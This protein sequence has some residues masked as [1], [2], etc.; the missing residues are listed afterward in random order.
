MSSPTSADVP[1]ADASLSPTR[2]LSG[3]VQI[4]TLRPTPSRPA[5]AQVNSVMAI[6][7]TDDYSGILNRER[8][9]ELMR[10]RMGLS[11]ELLREV[12]QY[13]LALMERVLNSGDDTRTRDA[14]V[15]LLWQHM[16][17][18]DS[19]DILLRA[20]AVTPARVQVRSLVDVALQLLYLLHRNDEKVSAAYTTHYRRKRLKAAETMVGGS[21]KRKEI[22]AEAARTKHVQP[23]WLDRFP[24]STAELQ[25][26]RESLAGPLWAEASAELDRLRDP[27]R[28]FAAFGGPRNLKDLSRLVGMELWSRYVY[29]PWSEPAHGASPQRVFRPFEDG[30]A[31][32]PLRD[33]EDWDQ[34]VD[35]CY[36]LS[37]EVFRAVIDRFRPGEETGFASWYRDHIRPLLLDRVTF[38]PDPAERR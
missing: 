27:E 38:V 35:L 31:I 18:L 17:L 20:G 1:A 23:G 29:R 28:W 24:D 10:S 34:V 14:A 8:S 2:T 4:K 5:K 37:F 12:L 11:Y 13:G 3:C 7:P 26:I 19:V 21:Q 33:C 25:R 6:V 22:E 15:R 30:F 16:E 36:T 9:A 32:R